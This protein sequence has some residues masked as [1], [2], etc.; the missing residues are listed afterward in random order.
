MA[1]VTCPRCR[2]RVCADDGECFACGARLPRVPV[3]AQDD[4]PDYLN[5]K[6]ADGYD[7]PPRFSA[8]TGSYAPGGAGAVTSNAP[9]LTGE[10]VQYPQRT[11][12]PQQPV[13]A[14]S[15]NQVTSPAVSAPVE[16][17]ST[18]TDQGTISDP[19]IVSVRRL[20]G[21]IGTFFYGSSIA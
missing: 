7:Q 8:G 17:V 21:Y 6:S 4:Y 2:L 10:S 20:G 18:L 9:A 19:S 11:Q 5:N 13:P 1:I 14:Y 3:R 16:V 15:Q 12:E